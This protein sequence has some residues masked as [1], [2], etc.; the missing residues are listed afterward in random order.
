MLGKNIDEATPKTGAFPPSSKMP[1]RSIGTVIALTMLVLGL[2][3]FNILFSIQA[4]ALDLDFYLARWAEFDIPKSAQMSMA[5]LELAGRKLLKYFTGKE[6]TPQIKVTIDGNLRPL[7]RENE[8]IHLE[9]VQVLFQTGFLMKR[10]SQGLILLGIALAVLGCKCTTGANYSLT[11][12]RPSPSTSASA[13]TPKSCMQAISN[14]IGIVRPIMGKSL[15]TAGIIL[16]VT[17][18]L[19]A[20]PAAFDFTGWWTNFH[21]LTF[22]N[23]L[24][25][26]DPDLDWLIKIFPEEFFF[27]AAKRTAL[28]SAAI[29]AAYIGLGLTLCLPVSHFT[30]N[31][32]KDYL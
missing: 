27:A 29:T 7:Y 8:M 20:L 9:D 12:G 16:A 32:S 1:T 25:R 3:G 22:E 13:R 19:L 26:L 30:A 28:Y 2:L 23:D 15:G 17:T 11:P 5:D 6:S 24:W 14:F 31:H 10:V 21:L 4:V 18:I